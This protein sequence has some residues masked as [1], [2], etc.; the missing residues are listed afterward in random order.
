[1]G[2]CRSSGNLTFAA[3]VKN[4]AEDRGK[5]PFITEAGQKR[6]ISG[7]PNIAASLCFNNYAKRRSRFA[8]AGVYT[9]IGTMGLIFWVMFV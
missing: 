8:F 7:Y 2:K 6:E 5:L 3:G 1:M 9:P 4:K